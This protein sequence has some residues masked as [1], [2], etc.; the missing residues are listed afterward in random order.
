MR[1]L[2]LFMKCATTP[3]N[4]K[5]TL[6]YDA[7]GL[8][9]IVTHAEYKRATQTHVNTTLA[10]AEKLLRMICRR[11]KLAYVTIINVGNV[12][13]GESWKGKLDINFK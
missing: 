1:Y 8:T 4:I 5:Q 2:T 10:D 7:N 6:H 13:R 11:Y 3:I 9:H 12:Y